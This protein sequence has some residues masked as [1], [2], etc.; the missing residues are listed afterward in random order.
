MQMQTLE[1]ATHLAHAAQAFPFLGPITKE[2][3]MEIV[4]AEPGHAEA[5][6]RFVPY[7]GHHAR[8]LGPCRVLHIMS[9][10]T[11]HAGLQSLIRALLLNAFNWCKVPTGGLP[12][13]AQFQERL[14]FE[15][16]RRIT[17]SEELPGDWLDQADAVVVFGRDE[18]VEHFHKRVRADQR[19]IAHPHRV[20]FGIVFDDPRFQ[21][22]ADVARAASLYDQ[23]GCL[24]PHL[25][26][27]NARI[28][29]EYAERLAAEMAAFERET[30]RG[31]I[32]LPEESHIATLR[33]DFHFRAAVCED[34]EKPAVWE[35]PDS[36]AWTVL[37][38][39]EPQFTVSCLNRVVYVKPL[40]DDLPKAV[41][42][43]YKHLSTVG[44]HPATPFNAEQAAQTGASRICPI[45]KMQHPPLTWHHDGQPVLTPL[46]H[47]V[48]FEAE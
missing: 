13:I 36:T 3:L 37:Y 45:A 46:V 30:P 29:R 35:S 18:T 41:S 21:S 42:R 8:A 22:V 32:S 28:A 48:D 17:I 31:V 1:L 7:N 40:P 4:R 47:W 2:G 23:Q 44:I 33:K 11:P 27:V 24:S 26:Y 38:D 5:L 25:F 9:G 43:V 39:P 6:D 15:L 34:A 14:P 20:S 10:N 12:E 19:F 16:A